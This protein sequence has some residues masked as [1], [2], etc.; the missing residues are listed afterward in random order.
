VRSNPSER[1]L[2][3]VVVSLSGHPRGEKQTAKGEEIHISPTP[4]EGGMRGGGSADSP[5]LLPGHPY[6]ELYPDVINQG[7]LYLNVSV[8]LS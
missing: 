7:V 4:K 2:Q 1:K 8:L 5:V 3:N 6:S